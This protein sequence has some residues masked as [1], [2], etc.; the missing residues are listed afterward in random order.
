MTFEAINKFRVRNGMYGSDDSFGF[1]GLFLVTL[2]EHRDS[3]KVIASDG[4]GWKHVSVS[5]N[6]NPSTTPRWDAM[7]AIKDL[8]FNEDECVVQ[9]HP[10][11]K[12]Y[13]NFHKGCLH[14][15]KYLGGEFPT[16]PSIFVGPKP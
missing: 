8:F 16:P 11:K 14:L 6:N 13:V 2:P 9:F 5:L 3:F 15:W 12:D 1:N 4:G 10:A 7:C